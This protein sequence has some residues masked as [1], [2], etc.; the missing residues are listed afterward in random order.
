MLNHIA[1]GKFEMTS[2]LRT[3]V[4][5][6]GAILL[7]TVTVGAAVGPGQAAAP[8]FASVDARVAHG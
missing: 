3:A 1:K 7:S 4:A 5:G 8:A 6:F 2:F